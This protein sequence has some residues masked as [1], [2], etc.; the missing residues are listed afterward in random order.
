MDAKEGTIDFLT[1]LK[2]SSSQLSRAKIP[3]ILSQDSGACH[4]RLHPGATRQPG[5]EKIRVEAVLVSPTMH[6]A[7]LHKTQIS[8]TGRTLTPL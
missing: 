6:C 7:S 5:S 4:S 1:R 3:A 8:R 2:A